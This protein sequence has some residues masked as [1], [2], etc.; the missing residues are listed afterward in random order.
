MIRLVVVSFI[1]ALPG[2][3]SA[4]PLQQQVVAAAR[5]VTAADFAFTQNIRL[6]RTG[7]TTRDVVQR[8]D[9]RRAKPGWTLIRVDGRAPTPRE[10]KDAIKAATRTPTPSYARIADWFGA[11]A[12]RVATT[13][14]S[15]TY[16]FARLPKGAIKMGP[17]DPSENTMVE[18][19]VNTAGRI[20]FVERARFT[21]R[22]PFKVFVVAKVDRFVVDTT[23]RLLPD[24]RPVPATTAFEFTGSLMGK[25]QTMKSQTR[26]A[27][28]QGV[29]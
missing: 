19:I 29:R 6:E 16:R 27:E 5:S 11:P 17:F 22:A 26:Y 21:S 2:V 1:V 8:Y 14:T 7:A 20:P 9:P 28:V 18:A 25:P 23:H 4:D 13:P 12:T 15:V 24:G 10:S 3:A